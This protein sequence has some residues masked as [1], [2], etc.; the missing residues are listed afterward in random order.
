MRLNSHR[1]QLYDSVACGKPLSSLLIVTSHR[2]VLAAHIHTHTRTHIRA[3]SFPAP[4]KTREGRS[5]PRLQQYQLPRVYFATVETYCAPFFHLPG[6]YTQREGSR[7]VCEHT[8][9]NALFYS[10]AVFFSEYFFYVL[11][12]KKWHRAFLSFTVAL[13][14]RFI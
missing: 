13:E 7:I 5:K 1:V 2:N 12:F 6:R 14:K 11:C 3:R 10:G 4:V 8:I 9:P